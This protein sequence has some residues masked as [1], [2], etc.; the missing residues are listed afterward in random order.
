MDYS[1]N[2]MFVRKYLESIVD[3][4]VPSGTTFDYEEGLLLPIRF[5]SD[6]RV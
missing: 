2:L 5:D 6:Q 4:V 1:R 3:V